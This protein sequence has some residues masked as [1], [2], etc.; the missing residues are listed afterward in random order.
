MEVSDILIKDK[1]KK[2][3]RGDIF[4]VYSDANDIAYDS[5]QQANRPAVIVSNDVCNKYSP[6]VE[7]VYLTT[8]S[9]KNLPTHAFTDGAENPSIILCEQIDTVSIKRLGRRCGRLSNEE[10]KDLNRALLISL[11]LIEVPS[12]SYNKMEI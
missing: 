6:T 3:K 8:R 7:V 11:G 4:Y 1:N 10:V 12:R 5:E 2:I 9:K